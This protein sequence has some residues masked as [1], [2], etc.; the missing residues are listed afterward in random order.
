[1]N[2]TKKNGEEKKVLLPV[3]T[4]ASNCIKANEILLILYKRTYC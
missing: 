1:M 2:I 4:A 3:V